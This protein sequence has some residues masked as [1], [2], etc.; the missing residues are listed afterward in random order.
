MSVRLSVRQLSESFILDRLS[1]GP[2]LVFLYAVMYVNIQFIHDSDT[3]IVVVK[4]IQLL[5][6]FLLYYL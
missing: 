4:Y 1:S 2:W 5:D 3:I 6:S